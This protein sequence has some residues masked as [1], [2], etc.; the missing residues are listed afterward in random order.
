MTVRV[1]VDPAVCRGYAH[2]VAEIPEVFSLADDGSVLVD[3]AA[4]GRGEDLIR[5]AQACPVA[6]ITLAE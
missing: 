6:A 2:C 1:R 5:A 4:A 3:Q